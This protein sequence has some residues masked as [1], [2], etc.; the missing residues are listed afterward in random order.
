MVSETA[1]AKTTV[2]TLLGEVSAAFADSFTLPDDFLVHAYN[3]A[4]ETLA[5][6][7]PAADGKKTVTAANGVITTGL[8]PAQ[9]RR[10]F[11]GDA[12]C[13]R[14]SDTLCTL[15]PDFPIYAPHEDGTAAV[16]QSGDYTVHFRA[17]PT[18]VTAEAAATAAVA[19][20]DRAL[21]WLRATLYACVYRHIGDADAAAACD[22]DAARALAAYLAEC[23]VRP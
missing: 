1:L 17:L 10:V 9:Y 16:T 21:P 13:L 7:D 23:G 4:A 11:F 12:E 3:H 5:L 22:A 18:P 6:L 15:L 8:A 14:G 2:G 19:A 20:D